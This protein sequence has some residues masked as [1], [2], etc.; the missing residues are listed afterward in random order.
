MKRLLGGLCLV[1]LASCAQKMP[2]FALLPP[3][4]RIEAKTTSKK[5]YTDIT[6]KITE[7][8]HVARVVAAIDA[9]KSGWQTLPDGPQAGGFDIDLTFFGSNSEVRR[10]TVHDRTISGNRGGEWNLSAFDP[11]AQWVVKKVSDAQ[12]EALLV[13]IGPMNLP[14]KPSAKPP[15]PQK[16]S[17]R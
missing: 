15:A 16:R 3:V 6:K 5:P 2:D 7:A 14:A 9:E 1:L 4:S 13:A 12:I 10:F 17:G 11:G 8:S